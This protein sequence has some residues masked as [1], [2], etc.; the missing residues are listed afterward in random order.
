MASQ[1]ETNDQ[2]LVEEYPGEMLYQILGA[3]AV[4]QGWP[5]YRHRPGRI[6]LD[7][8][9]T[10]YELAHVEGVII[11]QL[12]IGEVFTTNPIYL[13][14]LALYGFLGAFPLLALIIA[15]VQTGTMDFAVLFLLPQEILGVLLIRNVVN[16][17]IWKITKADRAAS[18]PIIP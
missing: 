10:D 15:T 13:C 18:F 12:L 5:G 17:V 14:F 11:R 8:L 2:P 3:N 1:K 16:S 6:G 4:L 9:D 7:P